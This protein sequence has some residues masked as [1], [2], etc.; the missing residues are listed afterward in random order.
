MTYIVA[1]MDKTQM[2]S[3][4]MVACDDQHERVGEHK[5][6]A[7]PTDV[8]AWKRRE[9]TIAWPVKARFK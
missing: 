3:L 6:V 9:N 4:Q 8:D 7:C 2:I 5:W 1:G